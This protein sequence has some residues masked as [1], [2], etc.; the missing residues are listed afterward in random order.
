MGRIVR[1]ATS[2]DH[3]RTNALTTAKNALFTEAVKG[4]FLVN[5]G[6]AVSLATWLQSVWEKP[7]ATHMLAYLWAMGSFGSGV[8]FAAASFLFRF[9]AFYHPNAEV[10]LRNWVWWVHTIAAFLSICA[11]GIGVLLIVLGGFS[12]L[13]SQYVGAA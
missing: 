7:W 13:A 2:E 10:P 8:F 12:A 6:G 9:L 4:L 3:S 5:G 1:K 11:F